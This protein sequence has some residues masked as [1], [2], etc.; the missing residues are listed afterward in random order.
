MIEDSRGGEGEDDD[1]RGEGGEDDRRQQIRG[2]E[3]D[4]RRAQQ[5][6]AELERITGQESR[7]SR[8]EEYDSRG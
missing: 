8:G 7:S 6:R 2:R 4:D 5:R 1:S 3:D